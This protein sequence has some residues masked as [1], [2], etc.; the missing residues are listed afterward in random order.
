MTIKLPHIIQ[1]Y[2]DSSNRHDMQSILSCFSD[3]AVVR[4]ERETLHG[5]KTIEDWIAK[6]I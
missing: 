4:D 1:S 3:E 2:V 5:K 6:T